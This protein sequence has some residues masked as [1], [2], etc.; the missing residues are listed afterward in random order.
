MSQTRARPHRLT[1]DI[2]S[3]LYSWMQS[4]RALDRLSMTD[5]V[6]AL[7]ELAQEDDSLNAR[8]SE[9]ATQMALR[10]TQN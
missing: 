6:R 5:R 1:I 7:I 4:Q 8:V 9:K 10:E 2:E 3:E